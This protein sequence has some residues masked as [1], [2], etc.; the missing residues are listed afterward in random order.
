MKFFVAP[1]LGLSVEVVEVE[2]IT[3][4]REIHLI[5][6]GT[7]TSTLE[8]RS[9]I[10]AR[11]RGEGGSMKTASEIIRSAHSIPD[12]VWDRAA[13]IVLREIRAETGIPSW[14]PKLLNGR[15]EFEKRVEALVSGSQQP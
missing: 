1:R 3:L 10:L 4:E 2:S 5:I 6:L 11:A 15:D 14:L 12:D 13:E 7:T 9:R 8:Y